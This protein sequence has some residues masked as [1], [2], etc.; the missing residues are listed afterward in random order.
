MLVAGAA[1]L[2]GKSGSPC[3]KSFSTEAVLF[4]LHN[5]LELSKEELDL[6]ILANIQSSTHERNDQVGEK[7]VRG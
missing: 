6:V 7:R 2:G 5:C 1:C 3:S 4:N